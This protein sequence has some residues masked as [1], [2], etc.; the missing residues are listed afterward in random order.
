MLKEMNRD[1]NVLSPQ[2]ERDPKTRSQMFTQIMLGF[3]FRDYVIKFVKNPLRFAIEKAATF[4]EIFT[5]LK[6]SAKR[7][8]V[9]LTRENCKNPNTLVIFDIEDK[10]FKY[11][12]NSGRDDLFRGAFKIYKGEVEH[13]PYYSNRWDWLLEEQIMAILDGRL[14][15]RHE[16][17][18]RHCWREPKPYG[19]KHSIVYKMQQKREEI[20]KLL[21]V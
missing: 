6:T 12:D 10:F 18:P 19:G 20:K 8:P 3:P 5:V 13:D 11:E 1:W 7:I 4:S 15:P 2:E 9:E 17:T 16:D 21:E 14:Q